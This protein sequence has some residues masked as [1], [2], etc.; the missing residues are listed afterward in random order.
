MRNAALT[1]LLTQPAQVARWSG[2][3]RLTDELHGT[4]MQDMLL[5]TE[6]MTLLAHRGSYKTT[7]LAFAMAAMLLA[8][9]RKN[10][11]FM[12]IE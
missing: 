12:R 7:C 3:E 11:I 6:D 10:I 4:W 9:P 2:L 8:Y 5:G 1:L